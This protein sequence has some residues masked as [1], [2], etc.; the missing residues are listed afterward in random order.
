MDNLVNSV[1]NKLPKALLNVARYATGLGEKLQD[2]EITVLS[3]QQDE[4]RVEAKV[5]GI[6]GVGGVGKTTLA[7]HFFNLRKSDYSKS[8][9]LFDVRESTHAKLQSKLIKDLCNMDV[10]IESRD[11]GIEMLQWHLSSC[12]ALIILDDID[13]YSQLEAL[14]L[15]IRD[16]LSRDSLILATSRDKQVLRSSGVLESS[17]HN[18]KG[19]NRSHS[20]ELF[21]SYAFNHP[22]PPPEFADLAERFARACD[23][24]PLSL[25]V[26]GA[27]VCGQNQSYWEEI[28]NELDKRLPNTEIQEKLKSSYDK[29]NSDDQQIFLDIACFFVGEEVDTAIRIWGIFGL[30]NL[31]DKCLLEVEVDGDNSIKMHDHIRDLARDLARNISQGGRMPRRLWHAT[32]NDIDDLLEQSSLVSALTSLTIVFNINLNV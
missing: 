10:K 31:Q 11:E 16:I 12:H 19:L 24:L 22:F 28:L 23:G 20:E 27:L 7:K 17:I 26:F 2:F 6:V 8:S 3:Q 30:Q 25:R 9:F 21:C 4:S 1:L 13:H 32:T 5:V 29:L 18:L 15:P 14:L